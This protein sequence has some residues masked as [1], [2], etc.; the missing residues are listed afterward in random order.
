MNEKQKAEKP[1]NWLIFLCGLTSLAIGP[2]FLMTGVNA[3]NSGELVPLTHMSGPMT[4]LQSIIA[5]LFWVVFGCFAIAI[6][7]RKILKRR[8]MNRTQ[9]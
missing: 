5:G 3:L 2:I 7:G 1:T 9:S 6:E 4:G 8:R